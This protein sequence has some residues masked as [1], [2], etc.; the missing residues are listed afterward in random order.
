[1]TVRTLL[2]HTSGVFAVGDEGDLVADIGRLTDPDMR[3]EATQLAT[4]FG[5]GEPVVP[6]VP[7]LVALAETHDRYGP[8]GTVF[9]YSNVNYLLL[10]SALEVVTGQPL[11]ALLQQRVATPLGLTK[12]RLAEVGAAVDVRGYVVDPSGALNDPGN[13][14]LLLRGN[15]ASGGVTST[16]DELLTI[17][18]AVVTGDL[19]GR[20]LTAAMLSP[21]DPSEGAYGLG[22]ASYHLSCGTF[23]GHAGGI[24]G[25]DAIALISAD[26]ADGTV[27]VA[28]ARPA[29]GRERLLPVAERLVCADLRLR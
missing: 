26:G 10:G 18:R 5:R 17:V 9:H 12:T 29:D 28:N 20:E 24:A 7:L 11:A 25:V 15:G 4:A 16:T 19:L 23:Y 3:A 1:V 13:A 2:D 27:L 6:S 21:S 8:P 22:I 14:H